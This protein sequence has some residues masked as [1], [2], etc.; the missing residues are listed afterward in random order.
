MSTFAANLLAMPAPMPAT[1]AASTSVFAV[2]LPPAPY[3]PP[4]PPAPLAAF[5]STF[6]LNP[7]P[8]PSFPEPEPDPYP[9]L[10]PEGPFPVSFN[11]F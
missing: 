4:P 9:Q 5:L 8:V 10:Y 2:N 1:S 11:F 3:A 7:A 6:A